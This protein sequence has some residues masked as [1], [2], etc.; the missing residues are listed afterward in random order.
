MAKNNSKLLNKVSPLIQG[1]VP[2]FVQADHP[3]FVNFLK[4]YY[5]YLEAGRITYT[6]VVEYI[7]QQT[8]TLEF[9][10][11]EDGERIVTEKETGSTGYFVNGETI[12]GSTS[13]AT[14]TVLVEDSRKKYIYIS[15]QQ[16]FITGE[17]FTGGTSGAEGT[18]SEYRAN[19]VQNIQ[20]LLEYANVDNTIYDFLDKMRDQFMN[21]IP[22]SLATGVSKRN[23]LKNIKD[24]Y[25]AKGTSEGHKLFFKAF[26]GEEPE[27]N[28]P[29]QYMMRASNGEWNKKTTLRV[30][31]AANVTGDEVINQ[32]ITGQSSEATAVVVAT[33][34]FTQGTYAVTELELQNVIGTFTDGETIKAISTTRDVE[35]SFTVKSQIST[36]TVT[37]DGILNSVSDTLT[38]ES[39]GSEVSEVVVEDI[40]TGSIDEII[41]EDVGSLY[42]VGDSI[43]FTADSNDTDI[44]VAT[45]EVSMVGGGILQE[46]G[47][48]DD[49]D[50][51][52]DT[53]RLEDGTKTSLID[54][55]I[56]LEDGNLL[57]EDITPDSSTKAFTLS[58][59]NANTDSIRVFKDGVELNATDPAGD[60]I[61]SVSGTTL[62][63]TT[64]PTTGIPYRVKG[65][66]VNKLLLNMTATG[67][68][69]AGH[70]IITDSTQEI[71]DEYTNN[72]LFVL[73]SGTFG[74]LAEATS[75]RKVQVTDGGNG[76]SKLPT[77][78]ITST[79]G[80][81]G[82]LIANTTDIGRA[83]GIEI[84]DGGF[85][86]SSSNPPDATF[87]AHFVLKDITGTFTAGNT[88]TTH[89]G[90]VQGWNSSTQ[91]LST[92][93]EN[94]VRTKGE[95][96]S[97]VNEGIQLEIGNSEQ[98]PH[99]IL[100]ED[101]LDFDDGENFL[102]NATGTTSP[103]NTKE[104]FVVTVKAKS[105]DS[106]TNAFYINGVENPRISFATGNTY[107]FD[108]SDSSLYNLD[109]DENHQ[110]AFKS[111]DVAGATT[112]G[113]VYTTGVTESSASTIPIGTAGSYIEIQVAAGAPQ[114]RYYCKNHTGM[115]NSIL[116]FTRPT[117]VNG[118]NDRIVI[119]ADD[120]TG[121]DGILLESGTS[122]ASATDQLVQESGQTLGSATDGGSVSGGRFIIEHQHTD[123]GVPHNEGD[124][125]VINRYR[126]SG[127]TN[128]VVME[129][130]N[131]GDE[132]DRISTQDLGDVIILNG[133]DSDSTNAADKLLDETDVSFDNITLNGTD[134]DSTDAADDIINQDPIDFSND[135]VTIT[136]SGGA[137]ATIVSADISTGT[138]TVAPQKTNIGVYSGIESLVGEDLNRL[139]DSYFYQDYSY[140]VRI[141]DSLTTYLN[142]LKKAV[143]PTGF[144]PFGKVNIASQI[145]ARITATA[146]GVAGYTGDEDTFSP[147]LASTFETIFDEHVKI[148]HKTAVGI[149]QFD[150][151]II[152]DGTDGDSSN[153]ADN[154]LY[155]TG[156]GDTGSG[157]ITSEAAKGVG[158]ESQRV[159]IHERTVKIGNHPTSKFKDN[160]LI[161]LAKYPFREECSLVMESG[162]GN[163]NEHIVLDGTKPFD[164]IVFFEF[165]GTVGQSNI[166]L[167][168]TDSSSSN[169]GDNVI[170]E[171][172]FKLLQEE[173]TEIIINETERILLEDSRPGTGR[174]LAEND[175]IAVPVGLIQNENDRILFSD[176]DNDTTLTFDEFGDIPFD[177]IL[178]PDEITFS[179]DTD[180]IDKNT[181]PDSIVMENEGELLLDGTDSSQTDAGFKLLQNTL[182]TTVT[183]QDEGFIVLNGTDTSSTDAGFRLVMEDETGD[184][185]FVTAIRLEREVRTVSTSSKYATFILEE[186]GHLISEDNSATSQADRLLI[187]NPFESGEV[188]LE[189]IFNTYR[190]DRIKLEYGDGNII[191]NGSG[192]TVSTDIGGATIPSYDQDAGHYLTFE[193]EITDTTNLALESYKVNPA[194]GQIPSENFRLSSRNTT[195]Y[196]SKY[197]YTPIVMPA[198]ITVRET[199]D[200]ALEDST[201]STHG[202][203]VLNSSSGSSTNAGENISLEGATGITF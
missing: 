149:D 202:F 201:D 142:E 129:K 56:A 112:G 190:N 77:L 37:N 16:K 107:R 135:N 118:E 64:A 116:T 90:T 111:V 161:H 138:L 29:N 71:E 176:D 194:E 130:G 25:G 48:L 21:A 47:T 60:T 86:L 132:N 84:K 49:S 197:G 61:W 36:S 87:Q 157:A 184:I 40:K 67:S 57:Q 104:I 19:P 141:G 171:D 99:G 65:S 89:T 13:K 125:L 122:R 43:T 136:D 182:E 38:I 198:E 50:I 150:E 28:Y 115:G 66:V 199:G 72:D 95:P 27:I 58:T 18:I 98:E 120:K 33:E 30:T 53:I 32:K 162:L 83:N 92:T 160:V 169:A 52:T 46:T 97:A 26:L 17:T 24:L 170:T 128:Y 15:S 75:L 5:Q 55:E 181:E 96:D 179:N 124:P 168:G 147:E 106:T 164:D 41:V 69:N 186:T 146:A 35:V 153:A 156:T 192:N 159:T 121:D 80:T 154:I 134:S 11:L 175:R 165:E 54:F 78:T 73:E 100:L 103:T 119:N 131:T 62:T 39:L 144:M 177:H 117:I 113:S 22:E 59:L 81:D 102:I 45:G 68:V 137:T 23:L 31:A 108:L 178:R 148:S 20:Q 63:F 166:I 8:N 174:L 93:F 155:E 109:T 85:A 139:Q 101:V 172:G 193:T 114:L 173:D 7:R 76:Y 180:N 3:V 145:S 2:D 183:T 158:G 195:A 79:S 167:N 187:D 191:M 91:V 110:L 88:L 140:E 152:L 34:T 105:A 44:S 74:T 1:Q 82:K 51:T 127:G 151:R 70:N 196:K 123:G 6:G 4:D 42:E 10:L 12:T 14:A 9:I 163:L 133:T 143:H 188:Q 203:L 185:G 200:V 126:E 94:V 189:D